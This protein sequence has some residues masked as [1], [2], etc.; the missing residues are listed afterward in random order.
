MSKM[1][2][3]LKDALQMEQEH[4]TRYHTFAQNADDAGDTGLAR[5]FQNLATAR[6]KHMTEIRK[7]LEIYS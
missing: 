7:Q 2:N 6:E 3:M 1:E 5:F 4:I